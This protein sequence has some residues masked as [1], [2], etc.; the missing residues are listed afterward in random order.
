MEV[1]WI[2][3]IFL[4]RSS[5]EICLFFFND[6]GDGILIPDRIRKYNWKTKKIDILNHVKTSK[7]ALCSVDPIYHLEGKVIRVAVDNY[8]PYISLKEDKLGVTGYF[9]DVWTELQQTLKFR[10]VYTSEWNYSVLKTGQYDVFLSPS[11]VTS[12]H[13]NRYTHA[14]LMERESYSMFTLSEGTHVPTWWYAQIFSADVWLSC[15]FFV[16]LLTIVVMLVFKWQKSL[17]QR[18]IEKIK[19]FGNPLHNLICIIG[20]SSGQGFQSMPS[21]W[22]L[23]ICTITALHMGMLLSCGFNSTLTSSLAFRSHYVKINSLDQAL[24]VGTYSICVR[25]HAHSYENLVK[26]GLSD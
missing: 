15:I 5:G 11:I 4:S 16:V 19:E 1:F 2:F 17:C 23:R 3:I 10:S 13:T 24:D 22:S 6:Q 14:S 9:G 20:A 7:N 21:S 25:E 18:D 8:Q 26:V 12:N